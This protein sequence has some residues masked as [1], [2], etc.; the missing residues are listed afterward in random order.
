MSL[1]VRPCGITIAR[2]G[3]ARW[4]RRQPRVRGGLVAF[5]AV[6]AGWPV[7][8]AIVGRAVA[9]VYD[10][11]GIVEVT[12]VATD[13]TRN[14]CSALYGA[15]ARWA[16]R[17][18]RVIITYP[19]ADEGGASLRGAGW[20]EVAR[21]KPR[22]AGWGSRP[23]RAPTDGAAKVRWAPAWCAEAVR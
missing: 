6:V 20:V 2:I 18:G 15:A 3:C 17:E 5:E 19:H 4:H 22:G 13:G 10:A 14:A 8:I 9:R 12:R 21:T 16:R 1:S 7:G 11:R 23:G